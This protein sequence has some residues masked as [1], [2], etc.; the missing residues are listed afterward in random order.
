MKWSTTATRLRNKG[1]PPAPSPSCWRITRAQRA[2]S[3]GTGTTCGTSSRLEMEMEQHV[4]TSNG[5]HKVTNFHLTHLTTF[6]SLCEVMCRG[7]LPQKFLD[8]WCSINPYIVRLRG[9]FHGLGRHHI[10]DVGEMLNR[11]GKIPLASYK[12]AIS[13]H[14]TSP[15]GWFWWSDGKG[16][17]PGLQAAS[18]SA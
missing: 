15:T 6:N 3:G 4:Q 8:R 5:T 14:A 10:E 13:L 11:E 18:V 2:S 9:H 12:Y 17:P 1:L 16:V 7:I